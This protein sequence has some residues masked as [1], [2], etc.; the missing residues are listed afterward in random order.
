LSN[1][2]IAKALGV[3][4]DSVERVIESGTAE[5]PRLERSE[6]AGPYHERII[7]LIS[8][9]EGN[10]VRVHE[11]LG[12]EGCELSYPALTA[13]CRRHGLG[14]EPEPR[15]GQYHFEPGEEMQHDTS[16]HRVEISEGRKIAQC[17]SL[18]LC[19][20]RMKF[21]QYYPNFDR[22]HC[23]VFLTD[24]LAYFE[25][26]CGRG[27]IDNTSVVVL[28]GS[29]S[30]MVPV[31]EMEAFA[32]RYGFTFVAHE[33]GDANRSAHVERRFH[34][35]ENNF[36]AGRKFKDYGDLNR[37]AI[38]WCDK[39][40]TRYRR[41][42]RASPRDLF[43]RE[44]RLL[45]ALPPWCPEV[46]ELYHRIVDVEGYVCVDTN[47]YSVPIGIPVGR[48]LEVRKLKERV[49]IY[50]GPRIVATH[51][52]LIERLGK[53]VTN[54]EHRPRRERRQPK[55]HREKEIILKEAPELASYVTQLQRRGPGS[56]TARLRRLLSM[57]REYP[58]KPLAGAIAEAERYGLFDLE[59]VERMVIARIAGNYFRL[60]YDDL[61]DP[62]AE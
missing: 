49:D 46:Y 17:A 31:P 5:V 33:I 43:A 18:V 51:P 32:R 3:S 10:L 48:Q 62:H 56:T 58:R 6:K 19:Y 11:E 13:Y 26:S 47:R 21:I 16:P 35:V 57:V 8:T 14:K 52:R 55:G 41:R 34:H 60:G 39:D 44:R 28:K 7:E 37:Q 54:A 20:S 12:Q 61:G 36:L 15:A 30:T 29:G 50:E 45:K 2:A 40:N 1:R 42:L 24:G 23:K 9:C 59:R 25:G 38:A 27:M 22:F 53:R 4:R